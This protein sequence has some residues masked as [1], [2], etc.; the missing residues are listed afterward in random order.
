MKRYITGIVAVLL[1]AGMLLFPQDAVHAADQP[2]NVNYCKITDSGRKLTVKAKVK[3]KTSEMGRKLYLIKLNAYSGET[4]TKSGTSIAS[5]KTKK[6]T[7]T[8]KAK[9]DSSMLYQKYA[10]ACKKG[11]KYKI[12]S[13]V[14][15]ITNPE[16]LATYKGKGPTATSK[17]GLQVEEM[18]DS[19]EV[20]TKHAVINWTL[21][22]LLNDNA[23][24][25]TAWKY[26][27]KTYYLDADQI[28]SNDQVVQAYNAAGVRVT[29]ILLL[30]NDSSST[31]TKSMQF[32]GNAYTKFSSFKTT[33][34]DGC[35][36]F[37]AVMTYLASHYGTKENL[38]C[39]WILGNE[40]NSAQIWNY[41][42]R[43]S[44]N[45][46]VKN[47]ARAYRICYN[48]VKSVSKNA[49]VYISLD[50][51]W[52]R[53]M[54][55]NGNQYFSS[56]AVL[57]AFYSRIRAEGKVTFQI[58]YHAY[59]QGMSDPIFW[60]DSFATSSVNATLVNFKNLN[61]LTNYVKKNFGS[62]YTIMLSEQS[63]N[64]SRGEE[65][66]AAAYA[67]AYYMSEANSMIEAFIYGRE[68][69]H[70]EE[71][72]SGYLWGLCDTNHGKRLLW[73]VFQYIDTADSF[74]F[75][76]PLV[77]YTNL[78]KWTKISGFSRNMVKS[79]ASVRQTGVITSTEILSSSSVQIT[80][81]KM[82]K[83]D[84]YELLRDGVCIATIAGNSTV[85]YTDSSVA[86]GN[87]YQYQVRMY[88]DAPDASD[89]TKRT[90]LY[91]TVSAPAAVTI[92]AGKVTLDTDKCDVDG[93]TVTIAW[94]K[95]SDVTGYEVLRATE[96]DGLY[97]AIG[98]STK[99]SYKDTQ[100]S[101]GVK[102]YYKV[103]AY[104][105]VGGQNF[106]G[107]MSE[108]VSKTASVQ[109]SVSVVNGQIQAQWT[110][111]LDADKYRLYCR[112]SSEESFVFIRP[113][114]TALN[115]SITQYC[116]ED[117]SRVDF[118]IGET[119]EF[120]VRAYYADK[121]F[122]S[123]S[124]VVSITIT[125]PISATGTAV[126]ETADPAD[127]AEVSTEEQE[128]ETEV[129]D[130]TETPTEETETADPANVTEPET[131]AADPTNMADPETETKTPDPANVTDTSSGEPGTETVD[132][133]NATE[134]E[135]EAA[136]QVNVTEPETKAA[137]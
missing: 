104:V 66:Q 115:T 4:G 53:D 129:S 24:N 95:L 32:G 130:P 92:T 5:A 29:I 21:N 128:S 89:A 97:T 73:N 88:K 18:S 51:N 85:T 118:S 57:D 40:V 50:N 8:L 101:A 137:D 25:K 67:Y 60:D 1:F 72:K 116:R 26:K 31:G 27:G 38:V 59:P 86:A 54:D 15:Y 37:E 16:T 3:Q 13:N 36:T 75:T 22:S 28:R 112:P 34:K 110:K 127:A 131:E 69:D 63:F 87:T 10:V 90:R 108:D 84:G 79:M 123:Y 77:K 64:S 109:L 132:P 135:T 2:V 74:K 136:G 121:V 134:A 78:K 62:K 113:T 58:A 17:K 33:S 80:W 7:V 45:S 20:G 42:G 82:N 14:R 39:G 52:T 94:K 119:Y 96:K 44:L 133:I 19:L 46:Y 102:Y 9:Y 106:Y 43:K 70:P 83:G 124:N 30:P 114:V 103:R 49:K 68:F 99:T 107:E 98:T 111:W 122:G 47:Y 71:M 55:G 6:G 56:K 117:A 11:G 41:G 35:R 120:K 12:L 100:T 105:T 91:G 93:G 76:D 126:L 65:T 48:A 23:A 61:V 125:E 81:D